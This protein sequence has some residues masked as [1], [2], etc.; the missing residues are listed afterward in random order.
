[1]KDGDRV[2]RVLITSALLDD[3]RQ[4][5]ST[6]RSGIVWAEHL[7]NLFARSAKQEL[8]PGKITIEDVTLYLA[9]RR[10]RGRRKGRPWP[11]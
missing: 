1:V 10:P 2:K 7:K 6:C 3:V 5:V 4:V 11:K 8:T 9:C